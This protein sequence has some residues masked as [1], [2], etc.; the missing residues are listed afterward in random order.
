M[1][2][3]LYDEIAL[4]FHSDEK[5]IFLVQHMIK[6]IFYVK[7]VIRRK[8]DLA[9][10]EMLRL[11]PHPHLANVMECACSYDKTI[12]IEEFINGCTLD[13]LM[14]QRVIQLQELHDIL[15]QLCALLHHLHQLTPPIIHRD[16]KPENILVVEQHCYLIDFE[17]AKLYEE[18]LLDTKRFG[19]IGYAAPEQYHGASDQRSDLYAIGMLLKELLR[20]T[21]LTPKAKIPLVKVLRHA[22]ALNSKDRFQSIQELEQAIHIACNYCHK[23]MPAAYQR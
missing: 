19:S 13:Y 9:L 8:Q 12:I 23:S 14:S 11:H 4:L 2:L 3:E 6:N 18:H 16:I 5:D 15:S 22:T 17:I 10:Y 21:P 1:R 20:I 7:K